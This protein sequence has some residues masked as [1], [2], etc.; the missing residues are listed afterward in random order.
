MACYLQLQ[1]L[2]LFF[3]LINGV[4]SDGICSDNI[5]GPQIVPDPDDCASFYICHGG[6]QF[7]FSCASKVGP[8]KVF[9]PK[10]RT[11]VLQGSSYDHSSCNN[12]FRKSSQR[13]LPGLTTSFPH[14]DNC[15][16]YYRCTGMYKPVKAECPYPRLYSIESGTCELYLYVKCGARREPKDPCDYEANQ[17]ED[18]GCIPCRQRYGTCIGH[19]DGPNQWEDKPWT[20]HFVICKDQRVIL[21][22]DCRK[23]GKVNIFNP[24]TRTC[25]PMSS[26][27]KMATSAKLL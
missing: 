14:E 2:V 11:C 9:D 25:M 4:I 27:M 3:A 13:C 21:Q 10:S 17:C 16:M 19:P 15:A 6:L 7:R 8:K 5:K 22:G 23:S 24:V 26:L 1:I 20:P 18:S 12:N